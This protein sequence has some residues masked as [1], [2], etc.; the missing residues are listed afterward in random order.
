V[1]GGVW[2]TD[3]DQPVALSPQSRYLLGLLL[4]APGHPVQA[5][6]LVRAAPSTSPDRAANAA[7]VAVSRL[8]AALGPGGAS[9]ALVTTPTGYLLDVDPSSVDHLVFDQL[10]RDA[11]ATEWPAEALRTLEAALALWTGRPF[12]ELADEPEL[13]VAAQTLEERHREAVDRWCGLTVRVGA[14]AGLVGKLEAAVADEPFRE[15]RWEALMLAQ[16]RAGSQ[17]DAIN[18]YERARA[19]LAEQ[20]GVEPGPRLRELLRSILDQDP[21]LEWKPV[22]NRARPVGSGAMGPTPTLVGRGAETSDLLELLG[23][24]RAVVLTGCAGIGKTALALEVATRAATQAWMV[25]LSGTDDARRLETTVGEAMGIAGQ[26]PTTSARIAEHLEDSSGLLVLDRCEHLAPQ[27]AHLVADLLSRTRAARVLATS[28]VEL[29]VPGAF[30]FTLGPLATGSA[31]EPGPAAQIAADH[32]LIRPSMIQDRWDDIERI[33][34]QADGV[35]L[36]LQLLGAALAN[37]VDAEPGPATIAAAVKVAVAS[38]PGES[39]YAVDVLR[40]LPGEIGVPFLGE[41]TSIGTGATHRALGPAVR[42][43]LAVQR[44]TT[45]SGARARLLLPVRDALQP[46]PALVA[47][48]VKDLHRAF[49]ELARTA[50]PSPIDAIDV[51]LVAALDDEHELG[52]WLLGRLDPDDQLDL[53]CDLVPIWRTCGRHV[54]GQEIMRGLE[55][56]SEQ[57]ADID[58]ARYWVR[59]AQMSPSL[60]DRVPMIDQLR[61]AMATAD[62]AGDTDL[63]T[64]AGC[65]LAVGLGWAGRL[66]DAAGL[67]ADIHGRVPAG[68]RWSAVSLSGLVSMGRGMAGDPATAAREL[69]S[70]AHE[71]HEVGH[72][73]EVANSLYVAATFA[74]VAGDR[75]LLEEILGEAESIEVDRFSGYPM[76][77]LAVERARLAASGDDASAGPLLWDAYGL[78][79]AHGEQRTAA[80]C[81]RD[82]GAWRLRQGDPGGRQDLAVAALSLLDTDPRAAAVAI[83]RLVDRST[84]PGADLDAETL[85][86]A[87]GP[88]A[89]APAGLPLDAGE[90]AEVQRHG[91]GGSTMPDLSQIEEILRR[92][93]A[94]ATPAE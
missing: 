91:P 9:A 28:R 43:G 14:V 49:R 27:V 74:R 94:T 32:A 86:R 37:G 41:L 30:T 42:A 52:L 8:R 51:D 72:H 92:I 36:V 15:R 23:R 6:M 50:A 3:R 87:V 35:P 61:A 55:P 58:R 60:A 17:R 89:D 93:A 45:T 73:G 11:D 1:L 26:E 63:A 18:T 71:Y 20:L 44:A 54:D 65:E 56:V 59:R 39:R 48:L 38:L 16:Y 77:G 21:A 83:A 78:L 57:A 80:A 66:T 68:N 5:E 75:A 53:A 62:A 24:K 13:R 67:I 25:S 29:D 2:V 81:R 19:L 82:L 76:A 40:A 88:L 10:L 33:C 22:R 79:R 7:R 69:L 70:H 84:A 12:G 4:R 46:E 47:V 31:P 34:E 90:L 64:R 85:A